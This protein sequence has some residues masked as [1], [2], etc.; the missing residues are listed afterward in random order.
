V[1]FICL[2]SSANVH[3][4]FTSFRVGVRLPSYNTITNSECSCGHF[5]STSIVYTLRTSAVKRS[6]PLRFAPTRCRLPSY[7]IKQKG[8]LSCKQSIHLLLRY[9]CAS[10]L[11]QLES[12]TLLLAVV[13]M[14]MPDNKNRESQVNLHSRF[15]L[16]VARIAIHSSS[17]I[18]QPGLPQLSYR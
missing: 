16:S 8:V 2:L 17:P 12:A 3:L 5:V 9:A 6:P 14:P 4:P 15:C 7:R 11:I 1:S 18:S 10:K 13:C